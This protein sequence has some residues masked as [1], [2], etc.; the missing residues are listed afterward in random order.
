[1][2]G[3]VTSAQNGNAAGILAGALEAAAAGATGIGIYDGTQAPAALADI[4]AGLGEAGVA[5]AVLGAFDT[6]NLGQGLVD[7]LNLYLPEVAQA[8]VTDQANQ[9]DVSAGL[10]AE[11]QAVTNAY[12]LYYANQT[13]ANQAAAAAVGNA[14]QQ[15]LTQ[16]LSA[17]ASN[18]TLAAG[19]AVGITINVPAFTAAV[20][21]AGANLVPNYSG[22]I[23]QFSAAAALPSAD[24]TSE[25]VSEGG[26]ALKLA[27]SDNPA[28]SGPPSQINV[29]AQVISGTPPST[30]DTIQAWVANVA[31][32]AMWFV[33]QVFGAN[34][35]EAA[36]PPPDTSQKQQASFSAAAQAFASAQVPYVA[37]Q[38]TTAGADCSG[39]ID[40][41]YAAA[42][43][44]L[45][46]MLSGDFPS[47]P[48]FARVTGAPEIGDVGWEQ[49]HVVMWGGNLGTNAQ[50]QQLSI[51]SATK[52]GGP[53]FGAWTANYFGP[54]TYYRYI[55]H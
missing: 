2:Y 8:F 40:E 33:Q 21:A 6:G 49:G 23:S 20:M 1:V 29:T 39:S 9:T 44:N 51:W 25:T 45:G 38:M 47:S 43:I 5:T 35:A 46:H 52:P 3:V 15:G 28:G 50:G 4:A 19:Q 42:G 36:G 30:L 53:V 55:G 22:V 27:V 26:A 31:D 41:I 16:P 14:V 24:S 11:Y 18:G 17:A 48:L 54:V 32:D 13:T 10:E 12:T 34:S 7:S 37:G